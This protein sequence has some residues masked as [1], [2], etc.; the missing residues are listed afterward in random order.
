MVKWPHRGQGHTVI[1]GQMGFLILDFLNQL[2][3]DSTRQHNRGVFRKQE[4]PSESQKEIL[5]SG[6]MSVN[7][8]NVLSSLNLTLLSAIREECA[9]SLCCHEQ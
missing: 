8:R 4:E 9:I 7:S 5:E 6:A 3:P 2:R 1:S